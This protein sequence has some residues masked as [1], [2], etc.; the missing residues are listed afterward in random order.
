MSKSLVK[1]IIY[2]AT[3]TFISQQLISANTIIDTVMLG[4]LS[5]TQLASLG[6]GMN[7]YITLYLPCMGILLALIPLI[8]AANLKQDYNRVA[9]LL[10]Q[11]VWL[12]IFLAAATILVLLFPGFLLKITHASEGFSQMVRQYLMAIAIGM[13]AILL[14]Q[15]CFAFF[16]CMLKPKIVMYINTVA[17]VFKLSL[18]VILIY[19][20]LP[21]TMSALGC[22]IATSIVNWIMVFI[23]YG[24]IRKHPDFTAYFLALR[25]NIGLR[26]KTQWDILKIGIPVGLNFSIDCVFF[27]LIELLIARFGEAHAAINQIAANLSYF[28]YLIPFSIGTVSTVLIAQQLEGRDEV[29][30]RKIG[31]TALKLGL[32]FQLGITG[33]LIVFHHLVALFY[34]T[35]ASLLPLTSTLVILVGCYRFFDSLLSM[36]AGILRGYCK[37]A[38]HTT[39]YAGTLWPIGFGLGYYLAFH[40]NYPF[41]KGA[42]GFWFALIFSAGIGSLLAFIY[43]EHISLKR[44]YQQLPELVTN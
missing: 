28:T 6:I 4:H 23:A 7:I 16:S 15:V 24:V 41:F 32:L 18:N 2:L 8:S 31:K 33:F 25:K 34:T 17:I 30:A 37:T 40:S 21:K 44:R 27:T 43:Y 42:I 13:P 35:N 5:N 36:L 14:F 38:M 1:K 39:I 22:A 9:S 19:G 12:S 11:G 26:L 10:A 3:P 29:M 20:F